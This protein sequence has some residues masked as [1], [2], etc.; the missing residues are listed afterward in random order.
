M[1]KSVALSEREKTM[2]KLPEGA[3]LPGYPHAGTAPA[4][5]SFAVGAAALPTA[6]LSQLPPQQS[7]INAQLVP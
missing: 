2:V 4:L 3:A 6:L 1:S 5:P 7:A